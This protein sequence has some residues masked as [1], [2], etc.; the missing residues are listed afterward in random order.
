MTAVKLY[1]KHLV[2]GMFDGSKVDTVFGKVSE[3]RI[4]GTLVDSYK[5][6]DGNYIALTVDDG[7]ETIR[8]KAWRQDTEKLKPFTIGDIVDIVGRVREYNEEIYLSPEIISKISPNKWILR[9]LELMKSYVQ[10]GVTIPL[11]SQSPQSQTTERVPFTHTDLPPESIP[12]KIEYPTKDRGTISTP[13]PV[14]PSTASES[15]ALPDDQ[16]ISEH[17]KPGEVPYEEKTTFED[18]E[19]FEILEGDEVVETVLELLKEDMT[20]E[21]LIDKSGLD[22]IDVE[23]ALRELLDEGRIIKEGGVYKKKSP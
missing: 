4:S 7:T 1:I 18:I 9:E 14:T 6:E 20:K 15:H 11:P 16:H 5:T 23:L 10:S 21:I 13:S 12:Q 22:E 19:E 3:V 2:E 17:S 8:V